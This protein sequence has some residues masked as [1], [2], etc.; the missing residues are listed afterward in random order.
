MLL[1]DNLHVVILGHQPSVE[2]Q[3]DKKYLPVKF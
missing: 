3:S 2:D 1:S